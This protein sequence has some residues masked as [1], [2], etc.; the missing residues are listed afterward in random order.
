MKRTKKRMN[1]RTGLNKRMKH[2]GNANKSAEVIKPC[3]E[4]KQKE[5]R[6]T[7]TICLICEHINVYIAL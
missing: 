7:L 1:G 3:S 5:F 2:E 4:T 6:V